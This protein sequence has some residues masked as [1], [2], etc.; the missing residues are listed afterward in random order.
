MNI[1][2]SMKRLFEPKKT[3]VVSKGNSPDRAQARK[4]IR[5]VAANMRSYGYTLTKSTFLCHERPLLVSFFH[6]HKYRSGLCFRVSFG[7]RV[8]NDSLKTAALNGPT[9]V[10]SQAEYKASGADVE[11][12]AAEI[13]S[14]LV[15]EGVPWHNAWSEVDDLLSMSA[16]PLPQTNRNPLSGEE[17]LWLLEAKNG[18]PSAENV[19]QSRLLLGIKAT[20]P[21]P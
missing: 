6:F 3:M 8:L 15:S 13:T 19:A 2:D 16:G 21:N 4:V 14:L 18:Q 20:P 12:C 9:F 10:F 7:V 11:Q 5:R 17:R 1:L